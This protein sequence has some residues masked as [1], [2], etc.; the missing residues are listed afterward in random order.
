[1]RIAEGDEAILQEQP[2]VIMG[3]VADEH[4]LVL[5]TARG[6]SN[7]VAPGF[8]VECCFDLQGKEMRFLF[9]T[10]LEGSPRHHGSFSEAVMRLDESPTDR[11]S[12]SSLQPVPPSSHV[13]PGAGGTPVILKMTKGDV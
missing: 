4:L 2:L 8:L 13:Y 10:G 11:G 9:T 7:L 5:P 12:N 3:A 1:M 6:C